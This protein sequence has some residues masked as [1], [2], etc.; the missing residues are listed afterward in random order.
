IG[1]IQDIGLVLAVKMSDFS[2]VS[3]SNNL[4]KWSWV[5]QLPTREVLGKSL[6]VLFE[7]T[8]V[9]T[10][11]STMR[12][13]VMASDTNT[14]RTKGYVYRYQRM[15][16]LLHSGDGMVTDVHMTVS[17][18]PSGTLLIEFEPV[19]ANMQSKTN[20]SI[21]K[22]G[23]IAEKITSC[24]SIETVVSTLCDSILE[25]S[26]Y[27]R[28]MVY[29]F[30]EDNSGE[31]IHEKV[32]TSIRSRYKGL[33]FPAR[34]ISANVREA[35]L[36]NHFRLISNV[37]LDP[38]ILVGDQGVDLTKCFLRGCVSP[39]NLYLKGMGVVS[40]M[41][42]A[43]VVDGNLWG[44]VA[45]H[46]YGKPTWPSP[47]RRIMIELLAS[48]A[49]SQIMRH[50]RNTRHLRGQNTDNKR[51]P[52][53]NVFRDNLQDI[54]SIFDAESL[55]VK[56]EEAGTCYSAGNM[57][58]AIK[59]DEGG[60]VPGV[61]LGVVEN[62]LRSYA[63]VKIG[64]NAVILTRAPDC[65]D[66]SWGGN[67]DELHPSVEEDGLPCPRKSFEKYIQ[68]GKERPRSWTS[69]DRDLIDI[70][71]DF[72][73]VREGHNSEHNSIMRR[74]REDYELF[75]HMS[76]EL[77]TPFHGVISALNILN[78]NINMDPEERRSF[79][80]TALD[81]GNTMMRTLDS[82]LNI[83]KGNHKNAVDMSVIKI[84]RVLDSTIESMRSFG[85]KNGVLI[86]EDDGLGE[87]PLVYGDSLKIKHIMDNLCQN[88]IKF[89]E[90][91][92]S[93]RVIS[94]SFEGLGSALKHRE[95]CFGPYEAAHV[96][97]E[98]ISDRETSG[99]IWVCLSVQDT[100]CGISRKDLTILFN[101]YTQVSIGVKKNYQGTGL[102]LH[103]CLLNVKA[104]K[105]Q[106]AL[107]STVKEGTYIMVIIPMKS[108]D[109]LVESSTKISSGNSQEDGVESVPDVTTFMIVDDN[110]INLKLVTKQIRTCMG[111]STV[112]RTAQNG[113]L[114]Y[115]L[116]KSMSE[117]NDTID[118]MLMDHHMPVASGVECIRN[119]RNYESE[120]G[121]PKVPI[122]GFTAD[123][124][125]S[126][127][128]NLLD[129]GADFILSKPF[130]KG[131]L[132]NCCTRM[133]KTR[134]K[135]MQSTPP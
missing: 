63:C 132:L 66:V 58:W 107:A 45:Y 133:V 61:H 91:G 62:P 47:E 40:S 86:I 124:T 21:L 88:A 24:Q 48:V 13:V 95:E 35:Y 30:L 74:A 130:A 76:H 15:A 32:R 116:V 57:D 18:S 89:T 65:N 5:K 27:D 41:S 20:A 64:Q 11:E 14:N 114:G 125:D 82:I 109:R 105:G 104:M 80:K 111:D 94:R 54:L 26:D 37:E 1:Y 29:R 70:L 97:E 69:F 36:S 78:D 108:A 106:M 75:A 100:G 113:L 12:S 31:V 38:C 9:E 6:H 55:A 39:H 43:I 129:A 17:S 117:S 128:D 81:C 127:R 85:S 112:I 121:L 135:R 3:V 59:D 52:L 23:E 71:D 46:S 8:V 87:T 10:M 33:R 120:N 2:I 42:N 4:H 68:E 7:P 67:P 28:G 50:N 83:A 49:A 118:G 90:R 92:G 34:D 122:T 99:C 93:V 51:D 53:S 110:K 119:I 25:E 56:D 102:G 115:E 131:E 126:S 84:S 72:M 103:I 22:T 123:L 101:P 73:Q 77:R 134:I 19:D 44:L 60:S 96:V 16:G 98:G 79:T